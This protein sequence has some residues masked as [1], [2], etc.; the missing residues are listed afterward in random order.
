MGARRAN[1]AYIS[2][3][4]GTTMSAGVIHSGCTTTVSGKE[5]EADVSREGK[6]LPVLRSGLREGR[7]QKLST[8]EHLD[9]W[10]WGLKA[11]H[12]WWSLLQRKG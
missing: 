2:A 4:W 7:G 5:D 6:D 11:H 9:V 10:L 12:E 3:A 1:K 8:P